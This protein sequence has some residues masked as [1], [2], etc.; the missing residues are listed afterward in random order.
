MWKLCALKGGVSACF[1]F[2]LSPSYQIFITCQ[3]LTGNFR[4]NF[5][6]GIW[7]FLHNAKARQWKRS[8]SVKRNETT[9]QKGTSHEWYFV[10]KQI[11]QA[12]ST[13]Q[14]LLLLCSPVATVGNLTHCLIFFFFLKRNKSMYGTAPSSV[15][16][17]A[18]R[19]AW[20]WACGFRYVCIPLYNM[21]EYYV[22]YLS[23]FCIMFREKPQGKKKKWCNST[24]ESQ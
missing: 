17:H 19:F 12:T 9:K 6:R 3:T 1:A 23:Y 7:T 15:F 2:F 4:F 8:I 5:F 14:H 16:V 13:C 18:G 20:V 22:D 11:E 21:M 10:R 24:D